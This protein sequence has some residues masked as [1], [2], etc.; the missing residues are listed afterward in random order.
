MRITYIIF[1]RNKWFVGDTG[2]NFPRSRLKIMIAK[3]SEL[4]ITFIQE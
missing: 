2:I 3:V 4:E 1:Q